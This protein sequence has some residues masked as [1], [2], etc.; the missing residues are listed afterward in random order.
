MRG[1]C[2]SM[3]AIVYSSYDTATTVWAFVL[4]LLIVLAVFWY[5]RRRR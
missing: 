2:P 5:V 1:I 4:S 3:L